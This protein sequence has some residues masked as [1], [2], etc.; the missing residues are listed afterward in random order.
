MA[1]IRRIEKLETHIP[2][3]DYIAEGGMPK[4]RTTLI[5]GT[6]GSAKT[7]FGGQFLAAGIEHGENGV[8]VT[9]EES[10]DEVRRNLASFGWDIP[11]WEK[12]GK[13]GFVD[14][15]PR[16]FEQVVVVGS[17]D[18]SA[19][20]IRIEAAIKQ[21]GA[22]RVCV[23]SV[24]A[25][26][27][28]FSDVAL[29]R[30][31]LH[32]I[33][34]KLRTLGVTTL[35]TTER[36]SE[37]GEISRHGVEEFVADNVV[38]LRNVLAEERRRRTIEI[39]K[40]R[41]CSHLKGEYPF[42]IVPGEGIAVIPL[43]AIELTQRSTSKRIDSGNEQLDAICG[44]GFFRDSIVLVSGATGAGKTL[45]S[46]T[47]AH[48]GA[49]RDERSLVFAFEE[50]RDQL[51]RN[52]TGWGMPFDQHEK[53][54][55]LEVVCTYP[56]VMSL[57]DHLISMKKAI[58]RFRPQRIVLDSLTALERVASLRSFREFVIGITSFIKQHQIA[59]IFT[60]TTSDL[61]GGSS[62]T[63]RHISTITDSIV[64][65]RY[66]E[67]YGEMLRGLTLLKMRGSVHDKN[68]FEYRITAE[69][70]DIG[71]PF[72]NVSGIISGRPTHRGA[73]EMEALGTMFER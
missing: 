57:E 56:E 12:A 21:V 65:L 30:R 32:G 45:M 13:W 31:E 2:G 20:M 15:S 64:L 69:G 37:Y 50:S 59:A 33:I 41:G 46:T 11:A 71:K 73:P 8:F 35:L 38:I 70:L 72:R 1:R 68:I 43:A 47:F 16:P 55:K 48:A 67:V 34:L 7:V 17:Y 27:S 52:A 58:E 60:A 61:M 22:T 5:C 66:V 63:E 28:Q 62:V 23:D 14:A 25:L 3:F 42:T 36:V 26:F 51:F 24:G 49:V 18:L 44:G 4:R 39:L 10:A 6:A 54:G 29:I 40:F 53:S 19:L 9:F